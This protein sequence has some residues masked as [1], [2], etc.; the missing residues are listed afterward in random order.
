MLPD[1]YDR[2]LPTT[3]YL[4]PQEL[5]G[6]KQAV[7]FSVSGDFGVGLH[8]LQDFHFKPPLLMAT[9]KLAVILTNPS[10]DAQFLLARQTRPPKFGDEEYDSY[11]DSDLWDL[12]SV[13]QLNPLS[14][15]TEP[16]IV[17]K[18]AELCSANIL[19]GRLDLDSALISALRQAGLE[20][21]DTA[22][23]RFSKY[24]EE[25]DFGPGPAIDVVFL[26]GRLLNKTAILPE[27]CNWASI[28]SCLEL[29]V[30]V[31]PSSDRIGHLVV[32]GLLNE[33]MQLSNFQVPL[34]LRHQEY[35]PGI[36]V[37]P[38][39]SKT[40]RPFQTT[41]LV[42]FFPKHNS[43]VCQDDS[44][45]AC[46]DALIV[47]PGCR[48]AF[49]EELRNI[50]SA[51]PRKLIVFVTHHHR[52]HVDGLSII[53]KCN[54]D[55]VL[56]AHENTMSRIHK[57][58]WSLAST[59]VSGAEDIC[60]GGQRLSI[61]FAPGHTD[62]HMALLHK[63][64]NSLIVGDHCLGEG[65]SILDID[66]GGNLDDYY[67]STYKFLDL[68]PH[69]LIPMHGRVNMWPKHMLCSYLKNR[70]SREGA[71]LKAI[72][73]GAET[74]F[75]IVAQV[76]SGVDRGFWFLASQN[77]RIHVDHLATLHKLPKVCH[78]YYS[79]FV[80]THSLFYA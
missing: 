16:Q 44:F 23:W 18:G 2:H 55:A 48:S 40:A 71:I 25:A 61:I 15:S 46:G 62:G 77:V 80:L 22:E 66:S 43:Q 30:N 47:D 78:T 38:M 68:S 41:N 53:Q 11:S 56:L 10:N 75:D 27:H 29:I 63:D 69:V 7:G 42:V 58:D 70:R 35:P 59:S 14:P 79:Q 64:T 72:E 67:Q 74:L 73:G 5:F 54:S 1:K 17:V 4:L 32:T 52:D 49:H 3:Y 51:L 34:T 39:G 65:S 57:D 9:L 20:L 6:A 60:I 26:V 19:L 8:Q 13:A 24:V 33:A 21:A 50:M 31:K 37:V 12:P 36:T 76:Y 28:N 45:V